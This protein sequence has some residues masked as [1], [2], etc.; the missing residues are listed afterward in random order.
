MNKLTK[1]FATLGL[2]GTLAGCVSSHHIRTMPDG[3]HETRA[4][5]IQEI[6]TI[7]SEETTMLKAIASEIKEKYPDRNTLRNIVVG[8]Y[9][10]RSYKVLSSD[11]PPGSI[12]VDVYDPAKK[13][14][15][16]GLMSE[17]SAPVLAAVEK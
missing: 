17:S 4:R 1:T 15:Y 7:T 12:S 11:N 3:F 13:I 16:Q 10:V 5:N 14:S 8:N 2:V 6:R 9:V